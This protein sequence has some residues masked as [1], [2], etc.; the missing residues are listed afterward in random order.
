MSNT[1]SLDLNPMSLTSFS[2][3]RRRNDGQSFID[4]NFALIPN[5]SAYQVIVLKVSD[6]AQ[7]LNRNNTN[8]SPFYVAAE[9]KNNPVHEKSW[10]FTVGDGKSYGAF[11]NN[12][13]TRGEDYIV[14][15]RALTDYNSV[16]KF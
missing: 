14:Y 10:K 5:L 8:F 4:K 15:Q 7:D 3:I 16:S 12:E 6:C 2:F 1:W 11:V 13:L 9:L